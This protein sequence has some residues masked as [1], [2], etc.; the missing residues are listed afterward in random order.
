TAQ[1]KEIASLKKR[2]KKMERKSKSKTPGM[3]RLFKIGRSTQVVS[4]ED[5]GL[6]DQEDAS[7][8]GRKIADID[9]DAEVTL[10]DETQ[11]RNDDNLMFDTCVLDEQE[12]EVENVFSTAEVT[13]KSTITTIVDEL[14]LTRI[15]IEIKAAKLKIRGVMIQEP[16]EFTRTTTTTT[17]A[18]S[19]PP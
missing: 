17:P 12:V 9:A 1:A 3:K 2:V 8:Q 15:L 14:T 6:G 5:E 13:T 4:S 10:I 19:K 18:A 11:G 7:K 16:S